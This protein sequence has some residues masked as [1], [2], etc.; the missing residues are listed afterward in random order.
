MV[1]TWHLMEQGSVNCG[2]QAKCG[3]L[4]VCVYVT[5]H[6]NAAVLI[7][8]SVLYG[9]SLKY[10]ANERGFTGDYVTHKA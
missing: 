10:N 7:N 9:C 8:L 2:W 5:L 4:P 3:P 6:W 1:L